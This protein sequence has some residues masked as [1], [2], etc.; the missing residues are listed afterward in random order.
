MKLKLLLLITF[1]APVSVFAQNDDWDW[2]D[3]DLDL[4]WNHKN[5][6]M[7]LSY[8]MSDNSYFGLQGK[9]CKNGFY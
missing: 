7:S 9:T 1:L 3:F 4:G 8:G 2:S 6:Y 5:P